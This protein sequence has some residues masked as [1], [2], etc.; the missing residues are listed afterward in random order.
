MQITDSPHFLPIGSNVISKILVDLKPDVYLNLD[1]FVALVFAS[2]KDL[3]ASTSLRHGKLGAY[4]RLIGKLQVLQVQIE[5]VQPSLIAHNECTLEQVCADET[6]AQKEANQ[7]ASLESLRRG[8]Q[9]ANDI[10]VRGMDAESY[11]Q[12]TQK[13]EDP[14]VCR[15][16]VATASRPEREIIFGSVAIELGGT[17]FVPKQLPGT[18]SRLTFQVLRISSIQ[19]GTQVF[20]CTCTRATDG[21][22]TELG[23]LFTLKL[24]AE[25]IECKALN[26]A[27]LFRLAVQAEVSFVMSTKSAKKDYVLESINNMKEIASSLVNFATSI[28]ADNGLHPLS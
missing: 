16:A 28:S 19:D 21:D 27:H 25:C 15:H 18:L 6:R 26:L 9:I 23:Q 11:F 3:C 5:T 12:S 8:I 14:N 7:S 2:S 24:N 10:S 20:T 17:P 22:C 4:V 13:A 1:K